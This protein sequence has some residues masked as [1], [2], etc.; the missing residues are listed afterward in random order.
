MMAT[1]KLSIRREAGVSFAINAA[2]SLAFF[3]A[4]FGIAVRPLGWAAPD[5]LGLDFIPQSIA[6]SLMSALVPALIARRRLSLAVPV[7]AI[8]LRAFGCALAGGALG[9]GLALATTQ[10]DLP[11][12]EWGAALGLKLLYGGSLG[13]SITSMILQRMTR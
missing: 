3:L 8:V 6:V 4:V 12:I 10:A 11:A 5:A 1:A 9:A 7:R 13:A 2:L